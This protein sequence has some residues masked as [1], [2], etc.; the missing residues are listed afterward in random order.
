MHLSKSEWYFI[1]LA[2]VIF[3]LNSANEFGFGAIAL[4][5]GLLLAYWLMTKALE[6][7]KPMAK[8]LCLNGF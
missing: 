6:E 5:P 3:A 2:V 7:E 1:L 4:L 8:G